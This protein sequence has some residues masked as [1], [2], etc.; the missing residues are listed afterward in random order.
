MLSR[1]LKELAEI[2]GATLE[3]D[4][5]VRVTGPAA[6]AEAEADE[7]SYFGHARY[8]REL[9][10]TR[11]GALVAPVGLPISRIDLPVLRAADANRAFERVIAAFDRLPRRPPEGVHPTAVVGQGAEIGRGVAIGPYCVVGDDCRLAEGV[12]L[13]AHVVVGRKVSIGERTEIHPHVTLYERVSIGAR[14]LIH[15]GAVIG[16]DGF[17]FDPL[18]GPR[19]LEGWAKVP[20]AG[21]VVIEDEVEIGA[22]STVDR[23]R[24]SATRIGRGAK[25]DNLVHVGHNVQI[26]EHALI[27]A[28]VGIAGSSRIGRGAMLAGQS[29]VSMHVQIGDGAKVGAA[30]SVLSDVPAGA[31]FMGAWAKPKR[32]YLRELAELGRLPELARRV[33]ELERALEAR[34]RDRA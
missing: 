19:G 24:F 15:G 18:L 31:E 11:A 27:V 16:A 25:L 23:G 29:G 10:A 8:Q 28:Q 17:G 7:I 3:G 1:T 13:H 20:H 14:C 30:S 5:R 26:G 32:E 4:A 21:T 12:A 2:C 34:G 33:K 22:N 6:L 9:E